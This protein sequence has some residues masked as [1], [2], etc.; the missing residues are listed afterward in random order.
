LESAMEKLRDNAKWGPANVCNRLSGD[1]AA[2]LLQH[3]AALQRDHAGLVV[4]RKEASDTIVRLTQQLTAAQQRIADLE[5]DLETERARGIHT[6][7]DQ[8]QRPLC[9]AQR[10]A[11]TWEAHAQHME[12]RVAGLESL[13]AERNR[14]NAAAMN[15]PVDNTELPK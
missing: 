6:C 13:N 14:Q 11:A 12:R 7:H 9:V 1:E 4:W 15:S 5:S 8:C 10:K 3:I 2:T